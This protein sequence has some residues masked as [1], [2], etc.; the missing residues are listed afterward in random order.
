ME[1]GHVGLT[2]VC[3]SRSRSAS[4]RTGRSSSPTAW[5]DV[6]HRLLHFVPRVGNVIVHTSPA[7]RSGSDPHSLL[8]HHR[9]MVSH[10][11]DFDSR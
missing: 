7:A 5:P 8:A 10:D 11:H 2:T 4:R 1:S 3:T 9:D 6:E